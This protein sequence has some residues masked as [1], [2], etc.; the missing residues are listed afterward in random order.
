M[1]YVAAENAKYIVTDILLHIVNPFLLKQKSKKLPKKSIIHP[2]PDL[3]FPPS[4]EP[5]RPP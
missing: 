4:Y 2:F 5:C 1:A 3:L